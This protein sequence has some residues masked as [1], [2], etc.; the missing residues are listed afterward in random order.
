M[1]TPTDSQERPHRT[2][3]QALDIARTEGRIARA[4]LPLPDVE[5]L[6]EQIP[7]LVS[8]FDAFQRLARDVGLDR[9]NLRNYLAATQLVDRGLAR[10]KLRQLIQARPI[11]ARRRSRLS[12]MSKEELWSHIHRIGS[13]SALARAL[14]ENALKVH[15]WTQ[16][17]AISE[18]DAG[19]IRAAVAVPPGVGGRPRRP[20]AVEAAEVARLVELAGSL[21]AAARHAG[22]A[23]KTISTGLQKGCGPEAGERIRIALR[24]LDSKRPHPSPVPALPGR[25]QASTDHV[26]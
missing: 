5:T 24:W 2:F 15:A 6:F 13:K 4:E 26:P 22:V 12:A 21:R 14:G 1:N 7:Q 20:R 18:Q 23:P 19:R 25:A 17:F 11:P 8:G 3:E 16:H 9:D 10:E